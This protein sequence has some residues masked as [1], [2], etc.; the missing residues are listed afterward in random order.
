LGASVTPAGQSF[1]GAR[2]K[3]KESRMR[4]APK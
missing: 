2:N 4:G 3:E 1:R